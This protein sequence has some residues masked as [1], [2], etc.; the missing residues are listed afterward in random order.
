MH[1]LSVG[2]DEY[3]SLKSFRESQI[4]LTNAKGAF[5]DVLGEYVLAGILYHAKH[6]PSFQRKREMQKWQIEPVELV[7]TKT[8][9][10]VGYGDIGSRCARMCKLAFGMKTI[11][12]N[13]FPKLVTAEQAQWIDELV[14]LDEYDRVV[15]EADYVLGTLPKMVQTNDFFNMQNCFSK[16]KPSAIFMNIG[17]GTTVDEEDLS[18]ALYSKKIAGAVLDVFKVEPLAKNNRL[19]YAP[20]LFMTPHC[21]DQDSEWLL[22]TMKIFG[23]NLVKYTKG[24]ELHNMVDKQF[25]F[26][27]AKPKL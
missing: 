20:N 8:L 27:G 5:S 16:M 12:V 18:D 11:G 7:S 10:V 4:P 13:K 3:C 22:R 14:S 24:Q 6:I 17:R 15:A 2:C 19:W 23:G 1:S 26:S 21:A 9:V 25:T